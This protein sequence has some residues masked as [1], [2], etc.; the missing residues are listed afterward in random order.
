[1]GKILP[2]KGG[3]E[4]EPSLSNLMKEV[5]RMP[6]REEEIER[7]IYLSDFEKLEQTIRES[8]LKTLPRNCQNSDYFYCGTY[9]SSVIARSAESP[10]KSWYIIDYLADINDINDYLGWQKAADTCFV[11]CAIFPTRCERKM[12]RYRDY[13]VM[14]KGLYGTF[15]GKSQKKIAYLMSVNY[16]EIVEITQEAIKTLSL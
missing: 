16:K 7:G 15:Y 14:G 5:R 2:F 3:P 12:M 10:P 13:L 11:L 8:I 9:V 1:M 6:A 4:N